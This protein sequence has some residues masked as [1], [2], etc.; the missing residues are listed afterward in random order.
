MVTDALALPGERCRLVPGARGTVGTAAAPMSHGE[1]QLSGSKII[2][3]NAAVQG[4]Q[5]V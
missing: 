1:S 5:A 2:C 3:R 4:F